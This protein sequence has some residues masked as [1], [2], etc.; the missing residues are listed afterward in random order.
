MTSNK[1][2]RA[3]LGPVDPARSATV[4]DDVDERVHARVA[5]EVRSTSTTPVK[6]TSPWSVRRPAVLAGLACGLAAVTAGAMALSGAFGSGPDSGPRGPVEAEALSAFPLEN[7]T[8]WVSYGDHVAV[9]HVDNEKISPVPDKAKE[10]GEGHVDRT[11][12]VIIDK[13]LY[14]RS[15]SPELP[16]SFTTQL[17]GLW[18][19]DGV[20][21]QEFNFRGT[22]RLESGHSYIAVLVWDEDVQ[23]FEAA[24][25]GGVLPFDKGTVGLGEIDGKTRQSLPP[26]NEVEGMAKEFNGSDLS[27]IEEALKQ[28]KPYPAA[29][30]NPT[31]PAEQRYEKVVE[32]GQDT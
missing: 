1:Q 9:I 11:G 5:G 4:P 14:N 30:A 20:G 2:L 22:S 27:E 6:K 29:A 17:A 16:S 12:R 25:L 24:A 8:D 28:A 13:V 26:A 3:T 15:G 7:T 21:T 18:W 32:A 31:L 19:E 10:H 23:G